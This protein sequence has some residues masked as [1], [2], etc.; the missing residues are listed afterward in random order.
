MKKFISENVLPSLRILLFMTLLLGIIYPVFIRGI[1]IV[2]F[3]EKS[4]GSLIFN[5]N[6]DCI[7]SRLIGQNFSQ[8]KYFHPRISYAGAYGYDA[9]DSNASNLG[10]S[11][12]ILFNVTSDACKRFRSI[13]QLENDTPIPADAVTS[14]ASGLDPHISTENA[15]LQVDRICNERNLSKLELIG[16]IQKLQ[17]KSMTELFYYVNVLE[18]NIALDEISAKAT[19][20]K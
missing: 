15:L 17:S 3:K 10:P 1:A 11:S 9:S 4:E 14:S 20:Q 13:N 19:P 6:G 5:E 7:G 18:L 12:R 8:M 2:F 16:L